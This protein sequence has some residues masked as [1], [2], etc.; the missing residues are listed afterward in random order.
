MLILI[1]STGENNLIKKQQQQ[2]VLKEK[3]ASTCLSPVILFITIPTKKKH[4][5]RIFMAHQLSSLLSSNLP[6]S[7]GYLD[8]KLQRPFLL[9]AYYDQHKLCQY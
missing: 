3:S 4:T 7:H 1:R 2:T 8:A 5:C 9:Y 6:V